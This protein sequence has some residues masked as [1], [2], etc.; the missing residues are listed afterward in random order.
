MLVVEYQ[1]GDLRPVDGG[2]K[3]EVVAPKHCRNG[4]PFGPHKVAVGYTPCDCGK[5]RARGHTT[6]T[7][8]TCGDVTVGDGCTVKR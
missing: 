4:H 3:V 2:P 5:A 6:W 1:P 8:G 7:C